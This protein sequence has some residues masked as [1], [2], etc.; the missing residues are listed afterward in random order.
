MNGFTLP[1]PKQQNRNLFKNPAFSVIQ[2]AASGVLADS[3]ALP[4]ES[5]GYLGETEWCI[6]ASGGTP[7][8]AFSDDDETVTFTGTSGTTAIYFL[9]RLESKD[10]R[11]LRDKTVTFSI[12]LSNSLLTLVTWEAFRPTSSKDTHGTIAAPS[13]TLIASGTFTVNSTVTRYSATFTL[14]SLVSRGLEIRLRVGAQTSGTWVVSQPQLEEGSVASDFNCD[15]YPVELLKCLRHYESGA[16]YESQYNLAG[17]SWVKDVDFNQEK[18][19]VAGVATSNEVFGGFTGLVGIEATNKKF[20]YNTDASINTG[21][22]VVAFNW[23]AFA[24]IP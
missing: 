5:I 2:G 15:D 1:A 9:Q 23:Q 8:Y 14:P 17:F 3:L 7:A 19:G 22:H 18:F 12:K 6:A 24:H 4:T 16:Y 10:A 13:Q 20:R 21:Q 11:R